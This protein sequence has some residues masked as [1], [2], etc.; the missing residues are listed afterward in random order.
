MS[1]CLNGITLIELNANREIYDSNLTRSGDGFLDVVR[2]IVAPCKAA[3][4]LSLALPCPPA[5]QHMVQVYA[6]AK[7][8]IPSDLSAWWCE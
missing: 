6:N 4:M 2:S 5:Y 8:Q 7:E 3:V 1:S